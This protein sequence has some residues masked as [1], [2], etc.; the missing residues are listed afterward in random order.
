MFYNEWGREMIFSVSKHG[1]VYDQTASQLGWS[2]EWEKKKW[3]VR[4]S[5]AEHRHFFVVWFWFGLVLTH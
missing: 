1:I 2:I 5:L 3:S 4:S